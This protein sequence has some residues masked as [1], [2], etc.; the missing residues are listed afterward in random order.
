MATTD[1]ITP[2]TRAAVSI[3]RQAH[4]LNSR[5]KG[6]PGFTQAEARVALQSALGVDEETLQTEG[7]STRDDLIAEMLAVFVEHVDWS[8]VLDGSIG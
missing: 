2:E 7:S 5:Y 4:G 6:Q 1:Q 8:I 3:I